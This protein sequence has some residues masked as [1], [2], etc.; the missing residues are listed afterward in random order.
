[1]CTCKLP[2][3]RSSAIYKYTRACSVW[4]F[5]EFLDFSVCPWAAGE[6]A[7]WS[8]EVSAAQCL[9]RGGKGRQPHASCGFEGL[10]GAEQG[11][12][13]P[14]ATGKGNS[15]QLARRQSAEPPLVFPLLSF[16]PDSLLLFSFLLSFQS[17]LLPPFFFPL[18]S[19]HNEPQPAATLSQGK[20]S[21]PCVSLIALDPFNNERE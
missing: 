10:Q 6:Q 11:E 18:H 12:P 4:G 7:L 8:S 1:M 13:P 21:H 14:T 17:A 15:W 2:L 3:W 16:I 5:L 19:S 9:C 20:S